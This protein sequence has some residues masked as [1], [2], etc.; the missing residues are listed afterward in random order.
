M[1]LPG[2][3]TVSLDKTL[4]VYQGK[5]FVVAV[6]LISPGEAYPLA[7]EYPAKK[8]MRGATASEGQSFISRNGTT[9]RDTTKLYTRSNVC[10]KAFAE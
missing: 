5:A 9:W 1:Q 10:L 2:Y 4:R 6:K 7:L 3:V 8:W